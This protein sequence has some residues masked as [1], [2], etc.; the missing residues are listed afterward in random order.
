[1]IFH[2]KPISTEMMYEGKILNVRRDMVELENGRIATREVIEHTG[3]VGI[4]AL[5]AED[6]VLM[7]RQYRYGI[8]RESLEIPAGKRERGEDP[9]LCGI[10]ELEEETGYIA[11]KFKAFGSVDPTPAYDSEVIHLF[12][13]EDLQ[14]TAQRLDPDEFLSVERIP[15]A[16]VVALCLNGGITDAKT[17]AAVMK[18]H[19]VRRG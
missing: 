15:F 6:R 18:L 8:G 14:P 19:A 13:A 9:R 17:L 12:L 10:R 2:E 1:M 4:L 7:V 16:E 11:G 5:D 3:G